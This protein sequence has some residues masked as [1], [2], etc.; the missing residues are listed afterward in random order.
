MPS[1]TKSFYLNFIFFAHT[2]L[3]ATRQKTKKM[4]AIDDDEHREPSLFPSLTT[5]R[6]SFSRSHE[7]ARRTHGRFCFKKVSD[8]D[9]PTRP[10]SSMQFTVEFHRIFF[11]GC[12]CCCF[13]REFALNL[14]QTRAEQFVNANHVR[15]L[16]NRDLASFFLHFFA[17]GCFVFELSDT[18]IPTLHL[19]AAAPLAQ[20]TL[21]LLDASRSLTLKVSNCQVQGWSIFRHNRFV[22]VKRVRA[23]ANSNSLIRVIFYAFNCLYSKLSFSHLNGERR[24]LWR[25]F[26][27]DNPL[28]V[29]KNESLS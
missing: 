18:S 16:S 7:E 1:Q 4:L 22:C 10:V 6:D 5:W 28:V 29:V 11:A 9:E 3:S 24:Q 15:F 8:D 12:C 17:N 27:A 23:R 21:L 13:L 26:S 25:Q 19:T 2:T 14:T 20:S